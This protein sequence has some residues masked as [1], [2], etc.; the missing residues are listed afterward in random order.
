[1]LSSGEAKGTPSLAAR[2]GSQKGA[3]QK[4]IKPS[5]ENKTSYNPTTISAHT[6][7]LRPILPFGKEEELSS[8]H[9]PNHYAPLSKSPVQEAFVPSKK[10]A[11]D[12]G[13][14]SS[15]SSPQHKATT[16]SSSG[17]TSKLTPSPVTLLCQVLDDILATSKNDLPDQFTLTQQ[18]GLVVP[19]VSKNLNES[20]PRSPKEIPFPRTILNASEGVL[21]KQSSPP[22]KRRIPMTLLGMSNEKYRQGDTKTLSA[23]HREEHL[24]SIKPD[25]NNNLDLEAFEAE[26]KQRKSLGNSRNLE[27]D[28]HE[29]RSTWTNNG[30]SH[31]RPQT[32]L[33]LTHSQEQFNVPLLTASSSPARSVSHPA[34]S[35]PVTTSGC[36]SVLGSSGES[37]SFLDGIDMLALAAGLK[38]TSTGPILCPEVSSKSHTPPLGRTTSV[39][40]IKIH[41]QVLSQQDLNNHAIGKANTPLKSPSDC[42]KSQSSP[43][44]R[45]VISLPD[46]P[47]KHALA[48][49]QNVSTNGSLKGDGTSVVLK[50]ID[51]HREKHVNGHH[52][53]INAEL[54][55][56]HINIKDVSF[57]CDKR[58]TSHSK[59]DASA[60]EAEGLSN[61]DPRLAA[62]SPNRFQTVSYH[63]NSDPRLNNNR[64]C[65]EHTLKQPENTTCVRAHVV[66]KPRFVPYPPIRPKVQQAPFI[67]VSS[68]IQYVTRMNERQL[69]K[70]VMPR[71]TPPLIFE[72]QS[73]P[74]S[75]YSPSPKWLQIQEKTTKI[76]NEE[77][78]YQPPKFS[79]ETSSTRVRL[80]SPCSN[81]TNT[82]SSY[83][84][85]T[86]L[87][88]LLPS[89]RAPYIP[90]S[91]T[92]PTYTSDSSRVMRGFSQTVNAVHVPNKSFETS[93]RYVYLPPKILVQNGMKS[94]KE[95]SIY[96]NGQAKSEGIPLPSQPP[97]SSAGES[98]REGSRQ[99]HVCSSNSKSL[100]AN[101]A[102]KP[103]IELSQSCQRYLTQLR[104]S[105]LPWSKENSTYSTTKLKPQSESGAIDR[106]NCSKQ[107]LK[108]PTP[109]SPLER[110]A[111]RNQEGHDAQQVNSQAST[112]QS[113]NENNNLP[114]HQGLNRV[115]YHHKKFTNPQQ[116]QQ[117]HLGKKQ[118]SSYHVNASSNQRVTHKGKSRV[119]SGLK[120][121]EKPSIRHP[122]SAATNGEA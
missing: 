98:H 99:T 118:S 90:R 107:S 43:L 6:S 75:R 1:M 117:E 70:P 16:S 59:E 34:K 62:V 88:Q 77:L 21:H 84:K 13:P 81:N 65:Q 39:K 15:D 63:A 64:E 109:I 42:S 38:H 33:H 120:L 4:T 18:C 31:Y 32:E 76:S 51:V 40:S 82:S 93:R 53:S 67:P 80:I 27:N 114:Q 86:L 119:N 37:V 7:S 115:L 29:Q 55:K 28:G 95:S 52:N 73:S 22:L 79:P 5:V 91:N 94:P 19:K 113:K 56:P 20:L 11:S 87:L 54:T 72:G 44:Q 30:T 9:L 105:P 110:L 102:F 35:I 61:C 122:S 3:A 89:D 26:I 58:P 23:Q 36:P 104:E 108:L 112:T 97:P 17:Y 25:N 85:E 60:L 103:Q 50:H 57:Q 69:T 8:V 71:L 66:S 2:F 121:S 12:S 96:N 100:H 24:S 48:L 45:I 116:L 49:E 78:P 74:N 41:N 46:E 47:H 68:N 10:T 83:N 14:F 101:S 92:A 111:Q 106:K